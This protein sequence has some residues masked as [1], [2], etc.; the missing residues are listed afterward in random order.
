MEELTVPDV[1]F[2]SII[3]MPSSD[4]QKIIRDLNNISE[5]LEIKSIDNQLIFKCNGTFKC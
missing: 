3:N 5:K 1:T 2:S 4:F